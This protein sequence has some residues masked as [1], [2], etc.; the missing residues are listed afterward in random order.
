MTAFWLVWVDDTPIIPE[1][2]MHADEAAALF[3][4]EARDADNHVV[5][6]RQCRA[7]ELTWAAGVL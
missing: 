7:A 2:P 4:S 3:Q 6:I 1:R 5:E